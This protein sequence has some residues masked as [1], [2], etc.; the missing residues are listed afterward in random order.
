MENGFTPNGGRSSKRSSYGEQGSVRRRSS[1][2]ARLFAAVVHQG[3]EGIVAKP[4]S[5]T[6]RPGERE[7]LKVKNRGYWRFGQETTQSRRRTRA[8]S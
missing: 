6:Y 3:L 2:T 1:T 5:R 8:M 4:R 7:W